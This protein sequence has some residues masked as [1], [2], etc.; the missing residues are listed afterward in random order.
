MDWRLE[1][2]IL[3][4]L[5][6]TLLLLAIPQRAH[7]Q[8]QELI[9]ACR[10]DALRLCPVEVGQAMLGARKPIGRCMRA[11][12]NELSAP[13]RAAVHAERKAGRL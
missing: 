5:I 6:A 4:L 1:P 13:C 12:W 10:G 2:I 8:S 9:D 7:P 3:P 11:H